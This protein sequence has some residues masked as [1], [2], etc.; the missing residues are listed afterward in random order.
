MAKYINPL[1]TLERIPFETQKR[2]F[3]RLEDIAD[4]RCLKKDDMEKYEESRRLVDNYNL[5][6]Y[7]AWIEGNEK[8]LLK[9][10]LEGK[11]EGKLEGL[12]QTARNLLMMGLPV[13]QIMEAT[14]LSKEQIDRLKD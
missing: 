5:G 1:E 10:K 3:K 11:R 13:S 6:M 14:G 12:F 8:G 7:S 4:I 2:I 9:G